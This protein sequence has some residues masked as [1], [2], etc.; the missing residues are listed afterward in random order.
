MKK[1]I[2]FSMTEDG[3]LAEYIYHQSLELER[4]GWHVVFLCSPRY[5]RQRERRFDVKESLLP[6]PP[7]TYPSIVRKLLVAAGHVINYIVLAFYIVKERPAMVILDSYREYLSPFWAWTVRIAS[8]VSGSFMVANLHDPVRNFRVGPIWWHNLS[9]R[10]GYSCL[11]LVAVHSD[12]P[13]E[14]RVPA[15][16]RVVTVPHGIFPFNPSGKERSLIRQELGVSEKD[17]LLLSFGFI[18]DNKNI[19]LLIR[20][21]TQFP[22]VILVVA[23]RTQTSN[24]KPVKF[25]KDLARSLGLDRRCIFIEEYIS[26]DMVAELFEACDIVAL[27]YS[28]SFYSQSGVLNLA[29]SAAKPV[30]VSSAAGPL[31]ETVE[32]FGLGKAIRPD[33]IEEIVKGLSEL[34][35]TSHSP[36]WEAYYRFAGWEKNISV[37]EEEFNSR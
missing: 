28:A 19:D 23:G 27:T 31:V 30:L 22:S 25:Y 33:S 7:I 34:L 14:A 1:V 35:V 17:T 6:M 20:A 18:R 11:H 16:V 4:K 36:D 26:N 12:V 8:A 10:Q 9:I 3:G 2:V 32:S 29:A 37:I 21:L 24:D 5:F 13:E 15:R